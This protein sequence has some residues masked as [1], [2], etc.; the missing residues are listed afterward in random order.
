MAIFTLIW[1]TPK[2]STAKATYA[3]YKS[4]AECG[5]FDRFMNVLC[6]K[7]GLIGKLE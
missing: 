6:H 3:P 5:K 7:L 4:H 2:V 1:T